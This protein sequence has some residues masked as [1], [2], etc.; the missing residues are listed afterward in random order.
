MISIRKTRLLLGWIVLISHFLAIFLL[1]YYGMKHHRP[2]PISET[3]QGVLSVAPITA[4]YVVAFVRYSTLRGGDI[5]DEKDG[6]VQK[7]SFYI[8]L[9]IISIFSIFLVGGIIY[10]FETGSIMF[11]DISLFTG[12][13]DTIFGAY[14]AIIF[15]RLFPTAA[16]VSED[17]INKNSDAHLI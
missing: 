14:L 15:N 8:Q 7:S 2:N 5:E 6:K 1:F 12:G 3:L 11:K 9:F 4:I 16:F 17:S 13:L 10:F